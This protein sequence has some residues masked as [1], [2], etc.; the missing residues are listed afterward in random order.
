VTEA[1]TLSPL[2]RRLATALAAYHRSLHPG[3]EW[4][5]KHAD[6]LN[7][8]ERLLPSGSGFDSG[9][10]LN[11]EEST[12]NRLVITT[13]YHHMNE[14]GFYTHWTDHK[15][16]VTPSLAHGIDLAISSTRHAV[17]PAGGWDSWKDYAYDVFSYALTSEE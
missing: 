13:S 14:V 1:R 7:E 12:A 11:T 6:T 2:Y 17:P 3:N 10:L 15:V 8:L 4:S 9:T 16:V 5:H